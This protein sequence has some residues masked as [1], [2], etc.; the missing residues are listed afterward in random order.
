MTKKLN[1]GAGDL[2]IDGFI[3]RDGARGDVLSPLPDAD[4]SIDEIR[5]SHVLE[6]FPY[7]QVPAVL[8]DWA[9]ALKPGGVMRI[10]VPDFE[11][12]ATAYMQGQP[13]NTQGYIM[14][15]QVDHRDFH[16]AIFDEDELADLLRQAGLTGIQR[17]VSEARDCAALPISLNLMG[18]KPAQNRPRVSAAMSVPRLGFM[19]N[20]F[21]AL[22]ALPKLKITLRKHTGAFWGQCLTRCM[23]ECLAEN[24]E[25]I[26][27]IDY[28]SVFTVDHVERL[29]ALAAAHPE[30]DAI[31]ALQV[32]RTRPEPL[33]TMRGADGSNTGRVSRETFAPDLA[34]VATAHFGLTLLR[35]SALRA[36]PQPWFRATPAD[37]G[38]W[39][40]GRIDEDIGFWKQWE[41]AGNTLMLANHVPIGHAELMVRWPDRNMQATWQ[42]PSEFWDSGPPPNIWR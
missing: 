9:R 25:W 21:C 33:M 20:F 7:A 39:G 42:H 19:D 30:A 27:T 29:L 3:P 4:A 10:A 37:D 38:G 32:H 8:Q 12:I 17:W 6:H 1:L 26:L 35:A 13:L 23:H 34:P 5:A 40:E 18:V 41:A 11:A 36:L 24:P 2:V 16:R 28:D 31:A 14:G 15:G 22:N